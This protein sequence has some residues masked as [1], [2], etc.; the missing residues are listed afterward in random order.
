MYVDKTRS[1]LLQHKELGIVIATRLRTGRPEFNPTLGSIEPPI[2]WVLGTLP[3]GK[4]DRPVCKVDLSHL[5]T[6]EVKYVS[7][8]SSAYYAQR[9]I[10]HTLG[11]P[12][13][14]K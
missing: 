6:A 8:W 9:Q 13:T 3:G 1:G 5:P 14:V 7:P 10:N 2:Q 12:L 4:T 11:I